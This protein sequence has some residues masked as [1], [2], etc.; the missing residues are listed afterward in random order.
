MSGIIIKQ[1]G[2]FKNLN[3]LLEKSL[4]KLELGELDR[5]GKEG[6]RALEKYTPK[7]TGKNSQS[8]YYSIERES[9]DQ[10]L[11]LVFNNTNFNEGVPIAIVIQYGHNT[12]NGG[13]IE[14]VD[15]IN[16]AL[17][18]IFEKL[19]SKVWEEVRK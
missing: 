6:V 13:W 11:K 15:Y 4:E 7:D 9:R 8:W 1:K 5:Y 16:P 3:S 2:D 17:K 10:I 19:V 18:P 12:V 14:G